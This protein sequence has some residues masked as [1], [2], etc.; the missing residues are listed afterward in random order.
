MIDGQVEPGYDA[1]ADAFRK[2]FSERDDLGAAV[3]VYRDGRPVVDL[4][5]GIAD[6]ATD[7]PW[8]RDTLALVF[9]STKGA[10]ALCANLLVER[11]E[12]DLEAPVTQYWPEF[13]AAGKEDI[14]VR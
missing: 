10:T 13:V 4:W 2:N 3:A 5:G 9:S 6:S 11:G 7:R 14:P 12:L 1:V 8:D